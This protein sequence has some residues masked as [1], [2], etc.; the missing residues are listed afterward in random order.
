[1]PK[2]AH[3]LTSNDYL[4]DEVYALSLGGDVVRIDEA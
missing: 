4:S 2:T 3:T 1:M